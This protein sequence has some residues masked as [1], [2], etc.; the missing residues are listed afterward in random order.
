MVVV[1]EATYG[2]CGWRV[3]V[4]D[5]NVGDVGDV[6]NIDNMGASSIGMS[7]RTCISWW[8]VWVLS[9][10]SIAYYKQLD[11]YYVYYRACGNHAY[12]L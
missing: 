4:D 8:L 7:R 10:L 1:T 5:Y 6:R 3:G 11:S 2:R 12:R 9:L